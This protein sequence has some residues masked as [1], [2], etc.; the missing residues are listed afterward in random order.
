MGTTTNLTNVMLF[1]AL[2]AT[3]VPLN[4]EFKSDSFQ[5]HTESVYSV[6]QYEALKY[7]PIENI[8]LTSNFSD[9]EKLEIIVDFSKNLVAN[10][11]DL[12]QEFVKLV[13]EN[14]WDLL[15]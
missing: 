4:Y 5:P 12:D 9:V 10:S 14:F 6:N 13:D 8:R 2:S 11:I 3:L 7:T 15:L 1:T